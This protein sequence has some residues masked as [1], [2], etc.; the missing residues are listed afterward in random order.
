MSQHTLFELATNFDLFRVFADH[1]SSHTEEDF[2]STS[3]AQKLRLLIGAFGVS[4]EG[5]NELAANKHDGVFVCE[6]PSVHT[7]RQDGAE[8]LMDMD[9]YDALSS[10]S[11][12]IYGN[13][14]DSVASLIADEYGIR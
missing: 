14:S 6:N 9:F 10:A 13:V 4:E 2:N 7:Q 11:G 1:S 5:R 3:V 12:H 8:V